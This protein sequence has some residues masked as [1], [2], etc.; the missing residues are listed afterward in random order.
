M[1]TH[2]S[3][4]RAEYKPNDDYY[5]PPE[6]FDRLGIAFDLDVCAPVGGIPWLP[7]TRHYSLEDDGLTQ[8][9]NGRVWMNPPYSKPG[10]WIERF[11]QHHNGI[12]LTQVSKSQG[13]RDLWQKVDGVVVPQESPLA[14]SKFVHGNGR[15]G[16]FM[17]VALFAYG[18]ECVAAIAKFGRV[19]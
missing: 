4:N 15:K 14:Q 10:P 9:W 6:V 17:P 7:A 19:R 12:C 1:V 16:I 2:I 11:I 18:E 13:F 8:P 3:R 5:T